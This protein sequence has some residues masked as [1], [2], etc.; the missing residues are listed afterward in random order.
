MAKA[1]VMEAID[2]EVAQWACRQAIGYETLH[3]NR[4]EGRIDWR[5]AGFGPCTIWA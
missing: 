3:P 5:G 1:L 2:A 4:T